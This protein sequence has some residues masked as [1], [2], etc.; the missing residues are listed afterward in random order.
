MN[1][2]IKIEIAIGI[3]LIL[4]IIIGGSGW[5]INKKLSVPP[6][7]SSNNLTKNKPA[8]SQALP[9]DKSDVKAELS[10]QAAVISR[11]KDKLEVEYEY[12]DHIKI[13]MVG[14][15]LGSV[16]NMSTKQKVVF[17][18]GESIEKGQAY[19]GTTQGGIFN[20]LYLPADK[21]YQ[22]VGDK[23]AGFAG[24]KVFAN[25]PLD[26][27]TVEMMNYEH[28][29]ISEADPLHISFNVG[30]GNNDKTLKRFISKTGD[31]EDYPPDYDEIATINNNADS[32]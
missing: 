4:A 23:P 17:S 14:V 13:T 5:L 3:I 9:A 18:S 29:S 25:V 20:F 27:G 32:F 15:K 19:L 8:N 16:T 21:T 10:N 7:V 2:N 1:K 22:I 11:Q 26:D 12:P 28:A 30:K 31:L 24:V 6:V